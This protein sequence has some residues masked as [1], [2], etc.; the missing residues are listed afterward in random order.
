MTEDARG[1]YGACLG[2]MIIHSIQKTT[3]SAVNPSMPR[4]NIY[5]WR[6]YYYLVAAAQAASNVKLKIEFK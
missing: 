6:T 5:K 3:M 1:C 2:H 4:T